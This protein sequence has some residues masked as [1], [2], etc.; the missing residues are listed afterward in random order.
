MNKSITPGCG[1]ALFLGMLLGSA[2][3]ALP[4]PARAS[5]VPTGASENSSHVITQVFVDEA[6]YAHR[7]EI[8]EARYMIEH[9]DSQAVKE[10]AQ[11]M[12]DDHTRSLRQLEQ[13]A[14]SGGFAMPAGIDRKDQKSMRRLMRYEGARLNMAYSDEQEKD[15]RQVIGKFQD[16]AH[17]WHIAPAVRDYASNALPTLRAHLQMAHQ[18]VATESKGNRPAG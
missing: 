4:R 7:A 5:P 1:A 6:A 11:K 17:D 10:F 9:T 12:I 16:V 13:V 8:A 15:H 14:S 3:F 2:S 18:L